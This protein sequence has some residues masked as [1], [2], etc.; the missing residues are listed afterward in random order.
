MKSPLFK[1]LKSW[2][3]SLTSVTTFVLDYYD[4]RYTKATVNSFIEQHIDYQSLLSIQ[5]TLDEYGIQSVA[6]SKGK[7][8][9]IDFETPFICAIQQEDW[10]NANF[11]LVTKTNSTEITYLD[12]T[13]NRLS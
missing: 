5:E 4:V 10:P 3:S 6:V 1:F 2:N 9:Y 8:S 11:T 12:P 13:T 7:Y